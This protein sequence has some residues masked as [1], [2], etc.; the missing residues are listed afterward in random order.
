MGYRWFE[1]MISISF[2]LL[3]W[4]YFFTVWSAW[5]WKYRWHLILEAV[6]TGVKE[7]IW[8][9]L[10]ILWLGRSGFGPWQSHSKDCKN[11]TYCLP[12]W[13]SAPDLCGVA[14]CGDVGEIKSHWCWNRMIVIFK[15]NGPTRKV[16]T[17]QLKILQGL[18]VMIHFV[19]FFQVRLRYRWYL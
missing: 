16:Q 12:A 9:D 6:W 4:N 11:Y 5:R 3:P 2:G 17:V 13:P 8:N 15:C 18:I 1:P 19:F 10:S 14:I 7:V